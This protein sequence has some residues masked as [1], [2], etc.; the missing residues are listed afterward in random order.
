ML[1]VL[2]HSFPTRRS[3][4]LGGMFLIPVLFNGG[5]LV[6]LPW[7]DADEVLAAIEKHRITSLMLVPTMIYALLDSPRLHDHDLS[8]LEIIYYGA[9]AMSPARLAEAIDVF[10]PVFFQFYGQAEAPQT[11][12]VMRRDEPDR[13]DHARLSTAAPRVG[14]RR[15]RT[16]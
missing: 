1:P 6:V 15:V 16:G 2:T 4:D 14:K 10:G 7:F 13:D 3:S 11:P 5:M 8:S 12:T 9:S